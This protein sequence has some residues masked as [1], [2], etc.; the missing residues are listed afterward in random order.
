M[1]KIFMIMLCVLLLFAV[2]STVAFAESI[3]ATETEE[4]LTI[5][6]LIANYVTD[7][8]E[9][10]LTMV[11]AF[12]SAV[13]VK[14][15]GGKLSSSVSTLN[16]NS[17]NIAKEAGDRLE[18]ASKKFEMYEEK[19][20][21]FLSKLER[22]EEEK[23]ILEHT[24]TNVETFLKVAKL[25]TLELSNEVAELLVLANIP[26]SKKEELYARHTK[27]VHELEEAEGVINND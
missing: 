4:N 11:A 13:I 17:I 21:E 23:K 9:E 19:M 27:A 16:N 14:L 5:T 2:S 25:A 15:I 22:S 7:N 8:A 1:K 12:A 10:I 26:N 18:D 24:V 20:A 6:E 3:E